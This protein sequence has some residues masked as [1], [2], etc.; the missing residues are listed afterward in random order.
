MGCLG[1]KP[2]V[3]KDDLGRNKCEENRD[4]GIKE[5]IAC[6]LVWSCPDPDQCSLYSLFTKYLSNTLPR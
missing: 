3:R 6:I 1:E 4:K 2:K 5:L